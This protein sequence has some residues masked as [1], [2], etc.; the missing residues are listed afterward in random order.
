MPFQQNWRYCQKC[1][2]M[3]FDGFASKGSCAAGGGHVASGFMFALQHDTPPTATAQGSWRYCERC[4]SMFYDG[5]PT[6]GVCPFGGEH[7]AAGFD[8]TL[9]HEIA[10]TATA[11]GTWRFCWNCYAMFYDGFQ[12]KGSCASGGGHEAQGYNFVL[13]HDIPTTLDFDFLPLVF[14]DGVSV[15]GS[16][17]LTIREDGTYTF[18]GHFHDS[19]TT[20]YNASV[21]CTVEDSQSMLYTFQHSGYVNGAPDSGSSDHDWTVNSQNN[22]IADYWANIGAGSS[23]TALANAEINI[24][25]LTTSLSGTSNKGSTPTAS[26]STTP[27]GSALASPP[28][29]LSTAAKGGIIAGTII[30]GLALTGLVAFVV[31]RKRRNTTANTGPTDAIGDKAGPNSV[32]EMSNYERRELEAARYPVAELRGD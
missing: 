4:S 32:P 6:Q 18:S 9:P 21:V 5:Y 15:D 14:G 13:P 7:N 1:H 28:A 20:G 25:Y 27:N 31:L 12:D 10:S 11:Q 8:F 17:H 22:S 24:G 29:R 2:V 19:G 3:F 23:A 16:S 26:A 30:A